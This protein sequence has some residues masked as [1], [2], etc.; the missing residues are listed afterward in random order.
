MAQQVKDLVLSL[1]QLGLLLWYRFD[2]WPGN[3]HMPQVQPKKK[4]RTTPLFFFFSFC[5]FRDSPKAY[6]VS[7]ARGLI[8]A[9]ATS[10][11]HSHSN[12]GSQPRLQPIPQLMAMP[13]P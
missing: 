4:K 3:F 2:P 1:Q 11:H 9:V 12:A 5:L 6:G 8:G 13:D 10:L 7:Q